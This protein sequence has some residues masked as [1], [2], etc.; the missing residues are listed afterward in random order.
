MVVTVFLDR[1]GV[2]NRYVRPTVLRWRQYHFLPGA[3]DALARLA[4]PGPDAVQVYVVTNKAWIGLRILST[5]RHEEI[6]RRMLAAIE[7]AGGRIDGVFTCPHTPV[8]GCDCR[9]PEP[10]LLEQATAAAEEAGR[11]VDKDHA[12][13]VG[14]NISDVGA[15][16]AFGCRTVLLTTTH[17]D[18][19]TDQ[20]NREDLVP[21]HV[22]ASLAGAVDHIFEVEGIEA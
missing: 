10:G 18:G 11:P 9:K 4:K 13:I 14:D 1:D 22:A 16:R 7:E 19:V 3:L 12:W 6:H 2:I 17:G 21:D 5:E 20:A 8:A 15:G